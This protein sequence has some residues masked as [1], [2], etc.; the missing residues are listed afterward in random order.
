MEEDDD[1]QRALA[2]SIQQSQPAGGVG[3]GSDE[4]RQIADAIALSLQQTQPPPQQPMALD[5]DEELNAALALSMEPFPTDQRP[6][7]P[8]AGGVPDASGLHSL[9]FGEFS[10]PL[11]ERQVFA[12]STL[13]PA[14]PAS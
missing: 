2:L 5:G 1:L 14:L 11:V 7:A 8:A 3:G 6:T 9:L 12:S 4:E 13:P 10:T